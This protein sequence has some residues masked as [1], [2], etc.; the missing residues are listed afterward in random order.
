MK[1][2]TFKISILPIIIG[3]IIICTQIG[4]AIAKT[5]HKIRILKTSDYQVN[6]KFCCHIRLIK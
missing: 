2:E 6:P 4:S 3:D 5:F 1:P